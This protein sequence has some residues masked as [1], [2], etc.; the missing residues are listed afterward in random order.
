MPLR[1]PQAVKTFELGLHHTNLDLDFLVVLLC[2]T[3][4]ERLHLNA[5]DQLSV[6]DVGDDRAV[7]LLLSLVKSEAATKNSFHLKKSSAFLCPDIVGTFL[8]PVIAQGS[9]TKVMF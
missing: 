2:T 1:L 9:M 3:E 5:G 7:G 8:K 6:E 4:A